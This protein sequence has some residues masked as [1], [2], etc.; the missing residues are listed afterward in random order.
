V[1]GA[2][3]LR[4]LTTGGVLDADALTDIVSTATQRVLAVPLPAAAH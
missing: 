4:R 3:G 1:P 2:A